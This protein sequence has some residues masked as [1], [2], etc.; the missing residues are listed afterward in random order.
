MLS[1]TTVVKTIERAG[2]VSSQPRREALTLMRLSRSH[3]PIDH[4]KQQMAA[5]VGQSHLEK[6]EMNRLNDDMLIYLD[7]VKILEDENK[8]LMDKIH[9]TRMRW[10]YDTK[11]VRD[12]YE[13]HLFD[14]RTR[15]DDEAN[16]KA[17]ADVRNKRSQ[18]ETNEFQHRAEDTN[19]QLE[20]GQNKIKNM[21]REIAQLR[22]TKDTYKSL[23]TDQLLDIEKNKLA[24]DETWTSLVE[25]LDKLDD[26][27]YKRIAV[28][29]NNQTLREHIDFIKKINEVNYRKNV[30]FSNKIL[31]NK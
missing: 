27:S 25:L 4:V 3:S 24:R 30:F 1:K 23:V 11:D 14:V 20:S 7:K 16:L 28:E 6:A 17:L 13:Q 22:D 9:E 29:F 21:E 26:E 18:F 12:K 10:G 19:K 5:Y 8:N 2:R 15:I 31:E